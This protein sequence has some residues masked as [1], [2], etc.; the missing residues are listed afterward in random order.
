MLTKFEKKSQDIEEHY[1]TQCP[2]LS[3]MHQGSYAN[4]V[5]LLEKSEEENH[6]SLNSAIQKVIFND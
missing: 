1:I 2:E 6:F 3:F 5:C 4:S